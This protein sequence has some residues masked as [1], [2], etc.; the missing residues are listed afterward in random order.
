MAKSHFLANMSHEIRTPMNGVIGM[1][2]LLMET[3][4]DG[5][6]REYVDIIRTSGESLLMLINDILD[7]SKIEAQRVDLEVQPLRVDELV[8][9][10]LDLVLPQASHKKL[11]L[12]ARID[13]SVPPLVAGD[14][15]RIRQV[16]VNLVS[17]AVKFTHHGEIVVAA[18]AEPVAVPPGEAAFGA[19]PRVRVH[20]HVQDTGIGIPETRLAQLFEPFTQADVSTTC[21]LYTSPSPRD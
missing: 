3:D 21:L 16:L 12:L 17:N 13:P 11:E 7:F 10:A 1:T 19:R 9:D 6:Q 14:A 20:L 15:T 18:T 4:L 8:E 5:P 2:S